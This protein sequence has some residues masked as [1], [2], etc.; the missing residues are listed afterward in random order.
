M[1][2]LEKFQIKWQKGLFLF[3]Q[4]IR[5]RIE[6]PNF[7]NNL[8]TVKFFTD[9]HWNLFSQSHMDYDISSLGEDGV[10]H[11]HLDRYDENYLKNLFNEETLK[12][13]QQVDFTN[14]TTYCTKK[15]LENSIKALNATGVLLYISDNVLF[16]E[17][18]DG[19]VALRSC[20]YI[21]EVCKQH[22]IP[23]STLKLPDGH[24]AISSDKIMVQK[25][26]EHMYTI[27]DKDFER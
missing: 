12:K 1:K 26:M 17:P 9:F 25:I 5:P 10:P 2:H 22:N 15:T 27:K 11:Q 6:H 24:H 14:V 23:L 21:E 13:L 16:D 20:S 7:L 3:L 8:S 18:S 4:Q 19:M